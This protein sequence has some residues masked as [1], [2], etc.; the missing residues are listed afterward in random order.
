M[1]AFFP[2]DLQQGSATATG[3][4]GLGLRNTIVRQAG[5]VVGFC[6][7]I[8]ILGQFAFGLEYIT[9]RPAASTGGD[10]ILQAS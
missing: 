7:D 4:P 3:M 8:V 2:V 6:Q 9:L 5:R 10:P 1:R